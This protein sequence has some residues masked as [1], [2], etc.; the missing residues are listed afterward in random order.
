[1]FPH[2]L[3]RGI[4]SVPR[5]CTVCDHPEVGAINQALVAGEPY[6]TVAN[7][8]ESLSQ[9]SVQRHERNHLPSTLVKAQEAGEVARADD[10]LAQ[11]RGLQTRTLAILQ[12]AEDTR[13]HR[14]ALSAIK[15]AR[16]NL[17]L[18]GKLAGEL[19][20]S[21]TVNVLL[22]PQWLQV[23]TAIVEVLSPYP[24]ARSAVAGKLLELE[25]VS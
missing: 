16:S 11:V 2:R 21:P 24:D 8:Y 18:L 25:E 4:P 6:R 15:E 1:M 22:S 20:D 9:A 10:L 14:T 13:Q 5:R 23:R 19:D 7:R 12:A 17:E 3:I